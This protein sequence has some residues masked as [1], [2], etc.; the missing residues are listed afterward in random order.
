MDP[1]MGPP[2]FRNSQKATTCRRQELGAHLARR[3]EPLSR[4]ETGATGPW[5][6]GEAIGGFQ[7]L[8]VP[9]RGLL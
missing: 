5:A 8:G 4:G 7:K 9:I 6:S 3:G 2:L 1:K